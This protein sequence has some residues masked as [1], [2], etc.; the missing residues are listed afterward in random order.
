[1]N[2]TIRPAKTPHD[3]DVVG[4]IY[5]QACRTLDWNRLV[6]SDVAPEDMKRHISQLA[7]IV[8]KTYHGIVILAELEGKI[9]G[10]LI[11]WEIRPDCPDPYDHQAMVGKPVGKDICMWQNLS[12]QIDRVWEHVQERSG[13]FLCKH[14]P[15]S[16]AL[17]N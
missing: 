14:R 10:Y 2:V 16:G 15:L 7:R 6:Y 9:V 8:L 1:M 13:P 4:E 5:Y 3:C 17:L 12:S 11:A